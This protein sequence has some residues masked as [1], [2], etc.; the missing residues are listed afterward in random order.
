MADYMPGFDEEVSI[1]L[2]RAAALVL[3]EY[4]QRSEDAE[5]QGGPRPLPD[6]AELAALNEMNCAL[7]S[8]LAEP[9]ATT[10]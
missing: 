4:L 6:D 8:L 1:S 7:E 9:F 3:F 2:S 10:I 5:R